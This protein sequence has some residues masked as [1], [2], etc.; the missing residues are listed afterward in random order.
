MNQYSVPIE[1]DFQ[2]T[3]QQVTQSQIQSIQL[4]PQTIIRIFGTVGSGKGTVSKKLSEFFSI[5]AFDTGKIWRTVTYGY[6]QEGLENTAENTDL[7][8]S[9]IDA[10]VQG[11]EFDVYYDGK[12]LD[13]NDLRNPQVDSLVSEYSLHRSSYNTFLTNFLE[14]FQSSLVLDGR[15]GRTPYIVAAEKYGYHIIK[16]FLFVSLDKAAHRRAL[17]YQSKQPDTDFD[18]LVHETKE[19]IIVRDMNDYHHIIDQNMGWVDKDT[20]AL[21]TSNLTI[22]EVFETIVAIIYEKQA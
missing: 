20:F 4:P 2:S 9:K 16:I 3:N 19:K 7:V 11:N 17:D 18:Q 1:F 10:K 8:F 5:P 12:K 15:G 6:I 21:D 22:D 14:S 13:D